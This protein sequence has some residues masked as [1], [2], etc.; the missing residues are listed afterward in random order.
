M[1]FKWVF[2]IG[3]L[4]S[5]PILVKKVIKMK[6]ITKTVLIELKK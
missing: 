2:K 4:K 6:K 5:S 1:D 3:L